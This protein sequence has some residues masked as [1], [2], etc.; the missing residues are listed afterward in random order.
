MRHNFL[1]K[2]LLVFGLLGAAVVSA[3]A[4]RAYPH[5]ITV[6]QPDGTTLT[7]QVH[8][9]EFLN[10]TTVG[11]R[12]VEKGADGFYYY[13]SF[14]SD[15]TKSISKT[16]AQN[17]T[18]TRS[19]ESSVTPPAAA[20]A[21]AKIKRQ[22]VERIGNPDLATG[23][24]Q[25]LVLLIEFS[26]LKFTVN[27]TKEQFTRL[28]NE[29]GYS[30]NG[31]TGSSYD[32]YY[33]NSNGKFDPTFDVYGP[34]TVSGPQSQYGKGGNNDRADDLLVEAC[35]IA[36]SEINFADYDQD[37]NGVVDNIFFFFA[38]HNAA[39]GGGSN[40]IWPHKWTIAQHG[41]RL[42]GKSFDSY[43]CTSEYSGSYGTSMAGIG[44][45]THE[46]GHVIGLPD[47]YDTDYA[48]NGEAPAVGSLSLMDQGS[49]NNNGR[50]PPYLG[51]FE[52][53]MLKW[54]N[55]EEWTES[56]IKT[57][58]PV[59]EDAAFMTPTSN[60]GEFYVYEYRNGEGYDKYIGATGVAIY[61]VDQSSRYAS[62]WDYNTINAYADHECY[63]LIE[64]TPGAYYDNASKLFPGTSNNT[65]FNANSTPAAIDWNGEPTGYNLSEITDLGDKATVNL[66]M[67]ASGSVIPEFLEAGI[68]AINVEKSY[69]NGD[70]FKFLLNLC[71]NV[72]TDLKWYYDGNLQ[73]E[74]SVELTTGT[75]TIEAHLTYSNGST[76]KI[77]AKIEVK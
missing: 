42:D 13:A 76:E 11:S 15:G 43:A 36:D 30:D 35:Q 12:L 32:Y 26:D 27:N 29:K 57:L 2:I 45:F 22:A 67:M 25:F 17:S 41:L 58:P 46:F 60:D 48:E 16:R 8:G 31:G 20:I 61:H 6:K 52:R 55:L 7:I 70:T 56:G 40:C 14:N 38:G 18:F 50:T 5:P 73:T 1:A 21:A 66:S 9:D 75:H 68:N 69:K 39:E 19:G 10:W 37:N 63:D 59:Q 4:V 28:L 49:Y 34:I 54:I 62:R 33:D 64:S 23:K 47:F 51:G 65:V 24:H 72:P 71:N 3:Y 77:V 74:E 44:T 53:Y